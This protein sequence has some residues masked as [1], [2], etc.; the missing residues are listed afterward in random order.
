MESSAAAA[1]SER[2][3]SEHGLKKDAIG[4]LDGLVIGISSTAPAYSLAA[5]LAIVVVQVG[6]QAPAVLLVSFIPMFLI[7]SAFY[8]MNRADPDCGTSFSWVTRAI[9]PS[10]GWLGGWAICTTG[11]LVVGSLADVAAFYIFDLFGLDSLRDDKVAVTIIAIV[12]IA[13][14]TMICVLGTELSAHFQR[15]LI[16]AQVAALLIF[17]VVALVKVGAGDAPGGVDRPGA[18]LVLALRGRRPQRA[19]ARAAHRR[20][21]LLG[22]GE[23]G[24]PERGD[25]RTP[26]APRAW[27]AVVSTVILL[28]TYVLGHGRGGRLRRRR[29]A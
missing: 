24:E 5:V 20:L 4:F 14:M 2:R 12:I 17:A 18:V 23:R 15:F 3:D 16:F 9:G 7:A 10:A 29:R 8:Y 27:P 13:V 26:T 6:V 25:A 28:V 22:L 11:I 21:H 1:P 19:R